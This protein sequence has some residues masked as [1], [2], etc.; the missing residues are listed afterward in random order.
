MSVKEGVPTEGSKVSWRENN[1]FVCGPTNPIGLHVEFEID[2][3]KNTSRAEIIFKSEHQGWD[4]VVHGGLLAAVLDDTMAYAV[5]TTDHLG[6][7][8]SIG[9]KYRKPVK[10]GETLHL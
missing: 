4:G 6:I 5:M 8:T 3:E 2:R 7:T 10:V 9:L 1:C